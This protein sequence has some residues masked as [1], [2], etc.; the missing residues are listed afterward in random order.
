MCAANHLPTQ[1]LSLQVKDL[2]DLD[3]DWVSG[4]AAPDVVVLMEVLEHV[5][6][7]ERALATIARSIPPAASVIFSV[8]LLGRLEA[9]WGHRSLFDGARV[10][11]MCEQAGLTVHW[12]EP[13]FNTW[14]LVVASPSTESPARLATL[15]VG[16]VESLLPAK[17]GE[18]HVVPLAKIVPPQ[19]AL[20]ATSSRSEAGVTASSTAGGLTPL[21]SIPV[22]G[23]SA[24]RVDLALEGH[25]VE[26]VQADALDAQDAV[27]TR[28]TWHVAPDDPRRQRP[29]THVLRPGQRTKTFLPAAGSASGPVRSVRL[30]ARGR[31]GVSSLLLRRAAYVR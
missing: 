26:V 7:P 8:P 15:G 11:A 5:P 16:S 4:A 22:P 3:A 30:S 14:V 29:T 24:L 25:D 21:L 27:V 31:A 1:G 28:W 9:C 10:R 18:Y 13:L 23:L 6:D 2:Y 20:D 19:G 17:G 12:V